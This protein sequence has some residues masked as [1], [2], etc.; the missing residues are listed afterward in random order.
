MHVLILYVAVVSNCLM[1]SRGRTFAALCW[2][3]LTVR[4]PSSTCHTA[5]VTFGLHFTLLRPSVMW[6]LFSCLSGYVVTGFVVFDT[7]EVIARFVFTHVF[8][9]CQLESGFLKS[10]QLGLRHA[11]AVLT[12]AREC[13]PVLTATHHS[14]GSFCDFLLFFSSTPLGVRPLNRSS[15]K[16]A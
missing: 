14:N 5:T 12:G 15:R 3:L 9:S 4:R 16:M 1:R 6:S 8:R 7:F 2:F 11:I 10:I 13:S